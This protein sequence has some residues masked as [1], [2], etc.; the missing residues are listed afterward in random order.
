VRVQLVA[1]SPWYPAPLT[2]CAQ[3]TLQRPLGP[4]V[5][6]ACAEFYKGGRKVHTI[7]G[8]DEHAIREA[9]MQYA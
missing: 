7:E 5:P 6:G 3:Q 2:V 1:D 9:V 8:A 4:D